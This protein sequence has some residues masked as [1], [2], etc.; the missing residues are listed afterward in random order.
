MKVKILMSVLFTLLWTLLKKRI[1]LINITGLE[2]LLIFH[3]FI[4]LISIIIIYSSIYHCIKKVTYD[5]SFLSPTWWWNDFLYL[6]RVL[7]SKLTLFS[8][9]FIIFN[10]LWYLYLNFNFMSQCVNTV[11][12][13]PLPTL[14][15]GDY[16]LIPTKISTPLRHTKKKIV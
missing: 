7:E 5:K 3:I 10:R 16:L 2:P 1:T 9:R 4:V 8:L 11:I 6:F 12:F 15:D 14:L 13:S